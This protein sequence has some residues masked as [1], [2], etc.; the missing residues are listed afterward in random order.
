[1]GLPIDLDLNIELVEALTGMG[2]KKMGHRQT[3]S[4]GAV[5]GKL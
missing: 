4:V 3:T 5:L 2:I 1:M